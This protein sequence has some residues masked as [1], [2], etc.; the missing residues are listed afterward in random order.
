MFELVVYA[1]IAS[2]LLLPYVAIGAW[3]YFKLEDGSPYIGKGSFS[4]FS[5]F[6]VIWPL[7]LVSE[8]S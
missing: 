6:V 8:M 4:E 5:F 2:L 1:A 7:L 3:L